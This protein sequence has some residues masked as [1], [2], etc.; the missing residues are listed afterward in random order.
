MLLSITVPP[1][2]IFLNGEHLKNY[3]ATEK[4]LL[5]YL[6]REHK[7]NNIYL[8]NISYQFV[9][10]FEKFLRRQKDKN[11]QKQLSNNGIMKHMERF[12]KLTNLSIKLEWMEKDPFRDYK[13]KFEKFDRAYLNQ[14]EL[15]I[16]ENTRFN[17]SL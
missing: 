13:M 5:K 10:G 12:K 4:Y 11:W 1:W 3:G 14:R 17:V 16:I 15:N 2:E 7:T 9:T 8:K 6:A